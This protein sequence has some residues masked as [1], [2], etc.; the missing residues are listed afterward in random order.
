MKARKKLHQLQRYVV[1]NACFSC[2]HVLNPTWC[3]IRK[4]DWVDDEVGKKTEKFRKIVILKN[5]YTQQELDVSLLYHPG[6]MNQ[7]RPLTISAG[8]PS[9]AIG[10]QR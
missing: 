10:T 8:R 2:S 9:F 6:D 7:C 3:D 5:M 4:L 1:S